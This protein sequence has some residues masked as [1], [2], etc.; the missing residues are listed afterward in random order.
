MPNVENTK[1]STED[2]V[3]DTT[4][5]AM[6]KKVGIG[7]KCKVTHVSADDNMKELYTE[8]TL[9][10]YDMTHRTCIVTG[11]D[12]EQVIDMNLI[13]EFSSL[14]LEDLK[15]RK[16][17]ERIKRLFKLMSLQSVIHIALSNNDDI[18]LNSDDLK[19]FNMLT[20]EDLKKFNSTNPYTIVSELNSPELL[21]ADNKDRFESYKRLAD[22]TT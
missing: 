18:A 8:G 13:S 16:N 19:E 2:T 5:E 4:V 7:N 14:T 9:K 6:F 21:K 3:S 1:G 15:M 12:S 10:H 20:L 17:N 22:G 11:S